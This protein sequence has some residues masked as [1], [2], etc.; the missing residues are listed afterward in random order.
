MA[1]LFI[2]SA[3]VTTIRKDVLEK[4]ISSYVFLDIQ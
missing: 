1:V 3:H 2:V 4:I